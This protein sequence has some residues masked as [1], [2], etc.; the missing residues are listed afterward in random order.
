M[1]I[2][3]RLIKILTMWSALAHFT[4]PSL[5]QR[6][7][8]TN[9]HP[10][11]FDYL[12]LFL[13]VGVLAFHTPWLISG[14]KDQSPLMTWLTLLSF[15]IVPTFFALSG[16]LVAGSLDRSRTMVMFFGLRVF[17]ILPA[18]AVEVVLSALILGPL[19][20]TE[21]MSNY[22]SSKE[23]YLY[24]LN[25]VGD[26]H[27]Y[28]PGVFKTN[29]LSYVNGQLWTVPY[30]LISYI[31]LWGLALLG[32]YQRRVWLLLALAGYY[33]AQ[34]INAIVVGTPGYTG[35]PSGI[36]VVMAFVSG[37]VIYKYRDRIAW[38]KGLLLLA[39]VLTLA[40]LYVKGGGRFAALPVAYIAAYF[41]LLNP[42][43]N[44]L[45]ESGDY[46]YGVYLYGFPI[47]QALLAISSF[48]HIW[49]WNILTALLCTGLAAAC[50]WWLVE[51]PV[52]AQRYRLKAVESHWLVLRSRLLEGSLSRLRSIKVG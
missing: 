17:R 15:G 35:F 18:L 51:K 19:L 40:C 27:Y 2:P 28:L 30:E 46:S 44:K 14:W 32:I 42:R 49:Y 13:A 21:T 26:I 48:F 34:V 33:V 38:S 41:G 23:F 10:S 25:I 36:N 39:A 1:V 37:L 3:L 52:L 12:R 5:Q 29:K 43:R 11:G 22:F 31:V 6:L 47:Q 7:E 16:F 8:D 50:S 24:F 9:G 4:A 20:T 45:I